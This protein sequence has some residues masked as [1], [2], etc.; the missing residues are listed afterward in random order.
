MRKLAYC[1][2]AIAVITFSSLAAKADP[3]TFTLTDVTFTNLPWSVSGTV[4]IDP[5]LGSPID[6]DIQISTPGGTID[7][8]GISFSRSGS[9]SQI[10][11]FGELGLDDYFLQL[12]L[13]TAPLIFSNGVL[14]GGFTG[15]SGGP[16]CTD[17]NPCQGF[18]GISLLSA[19]TTSYD[20]QTG[21]LV[22][23]SATPEPTTIALLGTGLI[24]M[25]G[26]IRRRVRI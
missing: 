21:S 18:Q 8:S 2:A 12:D 13:P 3:I 20:I 17:S 25:C 6:S 9:P 10:N 19:A 16:L 26:T 15:Y 24:G 4:S 1:L 11:I 5:T 23:T 22:Q 14:S 7:F